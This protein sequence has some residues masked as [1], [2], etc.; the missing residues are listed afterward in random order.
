MSQ[1]DSGGKAM[2]WVTRK[3]PQCNRCGHEWLTENPSP[4]RCARC[5]SAKWDRGVAFKPSQEEI[6]E[7]IASV[8]VK[9]K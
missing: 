4:K 9:K 3:I 7:L 2:A 8:G 1:W 6:D 5:K